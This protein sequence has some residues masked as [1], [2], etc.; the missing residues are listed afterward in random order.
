MLRRLLFCAYPGAKFAPLGTIKGF[1]LRGLQ[2]N[3]GGIDPNI[4]GRA[5]QFK[6]HPN[7]VS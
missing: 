6:N 5:N 3:C 2:E 1:C 4:S 7:F